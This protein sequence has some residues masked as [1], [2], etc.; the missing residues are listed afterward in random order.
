MESSQIRDL[1]HVPCLGRRIPIHC[2]C[3]IHSGTVS[4]WSA[5][6][7]QL[8]PTLCDPMDYSPPGS[9]VHGILQARMLEWVAMTSSRGS[10]Q[11]R[12]RTHISCLLHWQADSLPLMPPGKFNQES[13]KRS[14]LFGINC[15]Q[16][17]HLNSVSWEFPGSVS[18]PWVPIRSL[19]QG[20]SASGA[21]WHPQKTVYWEKR[22]S[23]KRKKY[24]NQ[25]KIK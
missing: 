4:A 25:N 15:W 5:K 10:S 24:K 8:C 2:E 9:Y 7:L 16:S 21:E 6:S 23:K 20:W 13:P 14:V 17:V 1:T 12:D 22:T 11:P 18:L 19:A 3:L